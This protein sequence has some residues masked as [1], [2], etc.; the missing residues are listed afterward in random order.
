MLKLSEAKLTQ[1]GKRVDRNDRL[2]EKQQH[3]PRK[4]ENKSITHGRD[5]ER[6]KC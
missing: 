3:G 6:N 2:E 5:F 1:K 4:K